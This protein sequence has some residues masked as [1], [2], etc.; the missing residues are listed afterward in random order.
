METLQQFHMVAQGSNFNDPNRQ[1]R[2]TK[3][4]FI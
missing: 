4:S 1:K 2:L 3:N